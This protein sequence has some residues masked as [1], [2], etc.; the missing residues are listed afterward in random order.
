[1]CPVAGTW[2][3]VDSVLL[4]VVEALDSSLSLSAIGE[5]HETEATAAASV[6]VAHHDLVI[7]E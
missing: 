5:G 6:T 4:L 1:M 2:W 3:D 7:Y